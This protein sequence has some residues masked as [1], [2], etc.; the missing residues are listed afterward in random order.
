MIN[1]FKKHV[2]ELWPDVSKRKALLAISGGLDSVV[3][4]HLWHATGW[5][6]ELAH[7]NFSLRGDE[8]DGDENFV[9][10]LASNLGAICH[11]AVFDT[12]T[13]ALI[14]KLSVQEAA[15]QLRYD[16]FKKLSTQMQCDY[17]LTA[18]HANDQLE[19]Y[20]INTLR[21]TG[22]KGLTGIPAQNNDI[23]RP[24]LPFSRDAILAYAQSHQL[25]WR[26]DSSNQSSDYLRNAIRLKVV[27]ELVSLRPNLISE[28][29][30]TLNH[31]KAAQHMI[32]AHIEAVRPHLLIKT[33]SGF[34]LPV[35]EWIKL[36]HIKT[37]LF[38]LL[39]PFGFH[40]WDDIAQMFDAQSGKMIL[41]ENYKLLKDRSHL[42]LEPIDQLKDFKIL[43]NNN[44]NI[45]YFNKYQLTFTTVSKL[46]LSD[47]R[48]IYVDADLLKWP[49][50]LRL[51]E[52]GD[53]FYPIGMTGSK[54]VSKYLKD[55]GVSV[56]DKARQ[57][58]LISQNKI[59]WIIG[60]RADDR[61]KVTGQT[62]AILKISYH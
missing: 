10:S 57:W 11:F 22:L 12:K 51:W 5:P 52:S 38:Y 3:L 14:H 48:A 15:R 26:E 30:Q 53:R 50:T 55:E 33:E 1:S 54:K 2:L 60:R 17:I 58:V 61:F 7:C 16:H 9:R 44:L 24:L 23:I 42:L 21:G 43:I 35:K 13:H 6:F 40:Q 31:L 49:L 8:S 37:Y 4:A 19:T 59:V 27:P 32:E 41:A 47:A 28:F 18:H 25:S 39:S 46:V 62:R 56:F 45:I 34:E 20:L 29:Q 36:N